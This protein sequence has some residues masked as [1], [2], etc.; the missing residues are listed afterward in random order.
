MQLTSLEAVDILFGRQWGVR[1]YILEEDGVRN[2]E[3]EGAVAFWKKWARE[4]K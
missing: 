4:R 3:T 2:L 1:S